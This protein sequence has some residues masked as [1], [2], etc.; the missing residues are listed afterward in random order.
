MQPMRHHG[1]PHNRPICKGDTGH[2]NAVS[3]AE[4]W[5]K[6][7]AMPDSKLRWLAENAQRMGWRSV[8]NQVLEAR[9]S[10]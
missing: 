4:M 7:E 9:K 8:A 6:C 3:Q 2:A 1:Q 5:R 10:S